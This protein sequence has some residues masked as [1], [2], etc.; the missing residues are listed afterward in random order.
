MEKDIFREKSINRISSPE[1]LNA[2]L[3]V[4]N[5]NVW[6]VL[7]AIVVML[8]G[9]VVWSTVGVLET[10]TDALVQ[11]D[12]EN[13]TVYVSGSKAEMVKEGMYLDVNGAEYVLGQV[14]TDEYGRAVST[15]FANLPAGK[16]QGEVII[17]RISPISFL[18]K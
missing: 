15:V 7:I 5:I 14:S 3:K 11:S 12:G 10:K 6:L 18:L 9:F 4:S 13:V 8:A 2:Y 16:Y 17:E 1:E